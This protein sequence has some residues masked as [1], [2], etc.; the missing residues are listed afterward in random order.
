MGV[1]F[2]RAKSNDNEISENEVKPQ[3]DKV[4]INAM[5]ESIEAYEIEILSTQED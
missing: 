2:R 4:N 3:L 1:E 5:L